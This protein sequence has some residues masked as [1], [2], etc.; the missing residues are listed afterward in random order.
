ME[1][2]THTKHKST[3]EAFDLFNPHQYRSAFSITAF[4]TS[5][6]LRRTE[7]LKGERSDKLIS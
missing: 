4:R 2:Q 6:S 3:T 1:N 7:E 5:L